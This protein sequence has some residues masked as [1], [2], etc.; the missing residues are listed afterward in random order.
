M[1]QEYIIYAD[2][3]AKAGKYCA[4]FYGGSL[5]RSTDLETVIDRLN[6][7]KTELNLFDEIKWE[8]VTEQYL[9]KYEAVVD[10]FFDLVAQDLIKVRIMFTQTA[11]IPQGL[12]PEQRRNEYTILYYYFLRHAFGLEYSSSL[13]IPI[14]L[15]I[16]LDELPMTD[17][18]WQEFNHILASLDRVD[19][20]NAAQ[21]KTRSD[22][23]AQVD[24]HNHV[25]LQCTD[26]VLGA[27]QFRLNNLHIVKPEG[28]RIR[29]KRTRAKDALYQRIN[30]RIRSIYPGFNIGITTGTRGDITNRWNDSYRH[31]VFK[32]TDYTFDA[33][34][35]KAKNK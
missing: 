14:W 26:I 15:R 28:S 25:L 1:S 19:A 16:Y 23:I 5:I 8:K 32:P 27:M 34:K 3:S 20:F 24:S 35:T 18:K 11:Y 22:Q 31:W 10:E 17:V 13:G 2:E 30:R 29:G 4:N 33:T 7:K 6:A 9:S 12:T 21:I